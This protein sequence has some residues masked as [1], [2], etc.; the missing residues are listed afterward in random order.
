M[1]LPVHQ[2]C[3]GQPRPAELVIDPDAEVMQGNL[4]GQARL[5]PAERMGPFPIQ[6]EAMMELIV[7][8]LHNLANAR[9]PAPPRLG[10]RCL[11]V[12]PWSANDL[13]PVGHPPCRMVRLALKAL[14]H[15]IR[16]P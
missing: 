10:P 7:N 8:G 13:G 4:G 16:T 6:P 2:V 1:R 15:D 12:P 11:T 3:K 14:G 5:Q 9:E